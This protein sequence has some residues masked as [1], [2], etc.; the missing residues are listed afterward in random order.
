MASRGRRA[1]ATIGALI[2][3]GPRLAAQHASPASLVPGTPQDS[4]QRTVTALGI[5]RDARSLGAAQQTV[6]G[7]SIA[8]SGQTNLISALAGR[9]AGADVSG[10][11]ASGTSVRLL[12]RGARTVAANDQPLFVVDGVPVA[13]ETIS[14][15]QEDVDY[16]STIGD[17]DPNDVASVTVL[18]GPNAAALY[19][20][21]AQN[22]AVL[23]TTRSAAGTRGFSLSARQDFTFESPMRLPAFQTRYALGSNGNYSA[24]GIGAWGPPVYG[25]DQVQWWSNG[26]P[27]L[28]VAQPNNLQDFL[29]QGH[30]STT[31]AAVSAAN[32][33]G[34]LRLGI[35]KVSQ[36]GVQ[37]NS[38][39][40]RLNTS[41]SAG[42]EVLPRLR[43]RVDGQY[44]KADA[45]DQPVQGVSGDDALAAFVFAG[46]AIDVAHLRTDALTNHHDA[47]SVAFGV[48]NPYWDAY[49]NVNRNARDH[50]IGVISADYQFAAWMTAS[51]RTGIDWWHDHELQRDPEVP[52][53]LQS[54]GFTVLGGTT[55]REQNSDFM[56]SVVRGLGASVGLS[57]DAGVATRG[58]RTTERTS[59]S[60]D[61]GR[62]GVI[63]D[64][65]IRVK[66]NSAYGRVGFAFDSIAFLDATG[67]KDWLVDGPA[68]SPSVSAAYDFVR[69]T[70]NGISGGAVSSGTLRMS[71]AQ[72]AGDAA[73]TARDRTTSWEAGVD[74]GLLHDRMSFSATYYD[75]RTFMQAFGASFGSFTE[76]P[77]VTKDRG[78]ELR[79]GASPIRRS[80]SFEWDAALRFGANRSRV[81]GRTPA[82]GTLGV[83]SLL[84]G[85]PFGT[86]V[87]EVPLRDSLGRAL[88]D[89]GNPVVI[90]GPRGSEL[91]S[92]VGGLENDVRYKH[93]S[94][95]VLVDSRHGATVYSNTNRWGTIL[96]TL[97]STVAIRQQPGGV[98]LP[99]VNR[100]GTPNT[101]PINPEVYY[102]DD[103][104]DA[105]F[106]V[107]D[108][109]AIELSEVR[110]GYT[111]QPSIAAR[112]HLTTLE[113]A[114]IGRNLLVVSHA[115][116]FDPQSVF[117]TGSG[118]GVE[119]F[120][121]PSTRSVGLTLTVVP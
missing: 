98:I 3:L 53:Q 31:T 69:H 5:E 19:G 95:M 94:L 44:A 10:T 9:V 66:T 59:F 108:G 33:R 48:N 14:G 56:L 16:G 42:M 11:G 12:L 120:G 28:L 34:D 65:S 100:D 102:G 20:S 40:S 111:V 63:G 13:N 18:D 82:L 109:S 32:A 29:V 71:W 27:A 104:S 24:G 97:A 1:A 64:E 110:L 4:V 80:G 99:G 113:V 55:Y 92:W 58:G 89:G 101:T 38:G 7:D 25:T 8:A 35:T 57:V 96:G 84:S 114:A 86:I 117:D 93:V 21:R 61:F 74:L 41:L 60:D 78:V 112:M 73:F 85:Q 77:L 119:T 107:V 75:E 52:D 62:T 91:P 68:F 118:Q 81:D 30:T 121:V 17:I 22:G 46:S 88:I 45:N 47:F 15:D 67:R 26:Q 103:G 36:D 54:V 50:A 83:A 70:P 49:D 90:P 23:I 87:A 76:T 106:S 79:L 115:P 51:I 37:P 2:V 43:I 39:L 105:K 116:N 6:R 72:V